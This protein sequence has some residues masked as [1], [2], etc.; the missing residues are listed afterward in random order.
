LSAKSLAGPGY[1]ILNIVRVMNII[2][3][4]A[5]CT[6]SVVMMVKTFIVSKFFFFDAC[7]HV[8]TALF[9]LFFIASEA[10]LLRT[11]FAKNWPLLSPDH[12]F[13]ALGF[14]MCL[15]GINTLGNLNKE[16]T[17][18]KSLGLAFWRIVIGSGIL[19]LVLGVINVVASYIFRDTRLGITARRVRSHGAVAVTDAEYERPMVD[20]KTLH[21]KSSMATVSIASSPITASRPPIKTFSPAKTFRQARASLLPSYHTASESPTMTVNIA[22]PA[23][24]PKTKHRRGKQSRSSIG[25]R[26]PLKISGPICVNPQFAHPQRP[27]LAHHP[28]QRR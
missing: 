15:L 19:I 26:M 28:S 12:G 25:P 4:L 17:S 2:G 21:S 1:I 14:G 22:S 18:Q 20:V 3:L 16:A 23:D 5:V 27:N 6:A 10:S 24:I 13:V 7:N 8:I 9:S 11:Y